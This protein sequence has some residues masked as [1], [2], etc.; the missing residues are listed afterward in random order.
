MI[1]LIYLAISAFAAGFGLGYLKF[2]LY[3]NISLDYSTADKDWIIQ[4]I[5]ALLTMGPFLIYIVAAA[6]ASAYKKHYI[7]LFSGL[8][9]A[10]VL[11]IG[12]RTNWYGGVWLYLFVVGLLTGIFN[13]AKNAVVPLQALYANSSAELVNGVLNSTYIIGLM[14]GIPAGTKFAGNTGSAIGEI[15]M[16]SAFI[17]SAVFGAMCHY[18]IEKEH[19]HSFKASMKTLITDTKVLLAKHDRF[20]IA[21]PLLWGV[22]CTTALAVVAYAEIANLGDN[23]KCSI[24]AIFP[25]VGIVIS[26]FV[27]TKFVKVRTFV[28]PFACFCMTLLILAIPFFVTQTHS[29]L[30]P[31]NIYWCIAI[32]MVILGFSFGLTTNLIEAEY[33][34][35]LFIDKKEGSG[36]ALLSA[37]TALVP[38]VLSFLIAVSI[39]EK[40]V[41][42][43]TQFCILAFAS[44]LA[45]LVSVSCFYVRGDSW[46]RRRFMSFT[47]FILRLRYDINVKGFKEI[48]GKIGTQGILFC[49]NHPAETDPIIMCTQVLKLAPIRPVVV[50]RFYYLPLINL[51]MK[52]V[53]AIPIPDMN[54]NP[55]YYSRQ[56]LQK[57]L[58]TISDALKRGDNVLFYPSGRI[59]RS[60]FERLNGKSGLQTILKNTPEA[61]V[62]YVSTKGLRGSM[63][64]AALIGETPP[65]FP[66]MRKA[67][68]VILR[69]FIFFIPKRKLDIT[70]EPAPKDLPVNASTQELNSVFEMWYN[71]DGEDKTKLVSYSRWKEELPEV[72]IKQVNQDKLDNIS[73]ELKDS[74]F[75]MIA[76]FTDLKPE[77]LSL[78]QHLG[79]D[80]GMDSLVIAQV[81]RK[82]EENYNVT[83]VEI[84]EL[85]TVASVLSAA[86]RG[87][88]TNKVSDLK[89]A[90]EFW[91]KPN[92]P[93][94]MMPTQKT[95]QSQFIKTSRRLRGFPAL[96]DETSGVVSWHKL[97]IAVH[98]LGE[99]I[100]KFPEERIGIMLPSTAGAAIVTMA[101]IFANKIPVMINWT[102]GQQ[103][104]THAVNL[105]GIKTILTAGAFLDKLDIDLS[106]IEKNFFLL[107]QLKQEIGKVDKLK[108]VVKSFLPTSLITPKIKNPDD[109]FVILFTSGSETVPKGV[110]LSHKNMLC[111]IA[112]TPDMLIPSP[113][114]V[115]LG[116]LPP[117]HSFGLMATILFPLLTG[118]RVAYHPNPNESRLLAKACKK[119]SITLTAG[120]PTFIRGILEAGEPDDF[121]TMKYLFVGAEKCPQSLLDDATRRNINL[122]EGYGITECSP[123]VSGNFCEG[124]RK[125][126]GKP[127]YDTQLLIVD[128]DTYEPLPERKTGLIFIR[129]SIVF[130]GYLD[131]SKNPF[132]EVNGYSWYNSGDLGHL[133]NGNLI[134]EGRLK[135]FAK[136]AGEMVSLPAIEDA[137]YKA[138][139]QKG[140]I[141]LV[142]LAR[143]TDD[144]NR[145]D[146]ILFTIYDLEKEEVNN[147]LRDAGF[148]NLARIKEIRKVDEIPLL[149]TGK[150]DIRSL[151]EML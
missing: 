85:Q 110:P 144:G 50:E 20:L 48:K 74:V 101:T 35:R 54:Q 78:T 22:G 71:K 119:W 72:T 90:P 135:R 88:S 149:G 116:F 56:R 24:L 84:L 128:P 133:D 83:D 99:Q 38:A 111:D 8:S 121:K 18:R 92:R 49:P 91:N 76:S 57:T 147:A 127:L 105:S 43:K 95:I 97:E 122:I 36:A 21:S 151:K 132:V 107:E 5:S 46:F 68:Q 126:G 73:D 17:V 125:G 41:S 66:A 114:N 10:L 142:V 108:A 117:F 86:V 129:G 138:G 30:S 15:I 148:P 23:V 14:A 145:P 100:K 2:F 11:L 75:K 70:F 67:F 16:Y 81:L 32:M 47:R 65:L 69:N 40:L 31:E 62:V 27:A 42:E 124:E 6:V 37:G 28:V 61:K 93:N 34:R 120:T 59:M 102:M 141:P 134:L 7:M 94:Q 12:S 19:L 143:E 60:G 13:P 113:D 3:T 79:A 115:I 137:L 4:L 44:L 98:L 1:K 140:D 25:V 33:L 89:P 87:K 26:S 45:G 51:I 136:I 106:C 123:I 150:T 64:S 131:K 112:G 39:Q 53:R 58:D 77:E 82:L 118:F 52:M 103:G 146:L 9:T 130:N 80:L 96:A 104:L 63:F 55:G 109:P 29:F 139:L